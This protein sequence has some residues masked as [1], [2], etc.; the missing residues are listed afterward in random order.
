L[1]DFTGTLD[2]G[3]GA[4]VPAS[5][6]VKP[7]VRRHVITSLSAGRSDSEFRLRRLPDELQGVCVGEAAMPGAL[8]AL[9]DEALPPQMT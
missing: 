8:V 1:T 4:A 2:P 3:E 9:T 6:A 7:A 5:L